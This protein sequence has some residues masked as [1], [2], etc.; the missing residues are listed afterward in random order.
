VDSG[1]GLK[2]ALFPDFPVT[3]EASRDIHERAQP[4]LPVKQHLLWLLLA[5]AA[6]VAALCFTFAGSDRPP[7]VAVVPAAP[8][9]PCVQQVPAVVASIPPPVEPGPTR[10]V[11][12]VQ[13][14]PS[15]P[16]ESAV[17]SAE[18]DLP[19]PGRVVNTLNSEPLAGFAIRFT[20]PHG[21]RIRVVSDERGQFTIPAVFGDGPVFLTHEEDAASEYPVRW[22]LSTEL[23]GPGQTPAGEPPGITVFAQP[24]RL[25]LEAAVEMA[26]GS[27]AS[28]AYVLLAFDRNEPGSPD[29]GGSEDPCWMWATCDQFGFARLALYDRSSIHTRAVL[30]ARTAQGQ[31]SEEVL[32]FPPLEPG[33]WK[34]R[35][36]PGVGVEVETYDESG[37]RLP[38][39][40]VQLHPL[41]SRGCFLA[42]GEST[43]PSGVA[44]FENVPP[45]RF[46]L[47]ARQPRTHELYEHD[48]VVRRDSNVH[49]G[50]ELAAPVAKL[51]VAGTVVDEANRPLQGVSIS[52]HPSAGASQLL[53]TDRN[54]RF[55][56]WCEPCATVEVR[57][58][59]GF[60]EDVFTPASVQVAFGT[61]DLLIRRERETPELAAILRIVDRDTEKSVRNARVF[62]THDADG[63]FFFADESFYGTLNLRFSLRDQTRLIVDAAGYRRFDRLLAEI[64]PPEEPREDP[65]ADALRAVHAVR[66]PPPPRRIV[67]PLT[68]GFERDLVVRNLD[69]SS[70]VP[71]ALFSPNSG[72]SITTDES[73]HV[74]L[75]EPVW[76]TSYRIT[77]DG[78]RPFDFNPARAENW[79]NTI[80]LIPAQR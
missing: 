64:L 33:P 38:H 56:H 30:S 1:D 48:F 49:L 37:E 66:L 5:L 62:L 52:V 65:P 72:R 67:I 24:P 40:M 9:E 41:Q 22:R 46:R 57:S 6:I 8:R 27:P 39:L 78:Y 32:L 50:F 4:R 75:D 21:E 10:E 36:E 42:V 35:I 15:L 45:G 14:V 31:S 60:Y 19:L 29:T 13:P 55:E 16:L 12:P 26:D 51:A 34:L 47:R 77:H 76:P 58:G 18:F 3:P 71:R 11:A 73:G 63:D 20:R 61:G 17:F 79:R 68:P 54:G 25:I 2:L 80:W 7:P 44:R 53:T 43:N 74:H 23:A 70:P 69:T 28:G 59:A